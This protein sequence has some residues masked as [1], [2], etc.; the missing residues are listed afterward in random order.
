L[1]STAINM[2]LSSYSTVATNTTKTQ[3]CLSR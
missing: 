1:S 2:A 3:K